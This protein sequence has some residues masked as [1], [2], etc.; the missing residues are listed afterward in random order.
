MQ[1]A[2][3][4]ASFCLSLLIL[5]NSV[6]IAV[7]EHT[8]NFKN[9]TARSY[10]KTDTCCSKKE[11]SNQIKKDT[12]S[13]QKTSCCETESSVLVPNVFQSAGLDF[14]FGSVLISQL[15]SVIVPAFMAIEHETNFLRF[16]D[17]SGPPLSVRSTL[18]VLYQVFVI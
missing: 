1:K 17:C 8:C 15:S 13:F 18:H 10:F 5:F 16:S 9:E 11:A 14:R 2:L 3:K 6:G 7:Y 12:F 4:I